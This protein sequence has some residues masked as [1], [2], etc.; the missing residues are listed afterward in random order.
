L[1][2]I[3]FRAHGRWPNLR[4]PKT[5][6]EKIQYRKLHQH[7]ERFVRLADK[8]LVKEY[9]TKRLGSDWVIPTLWSGSALP[10]RDERLWPI[11]FVLKATHGSSTNLF[12]RS[13][14]EKN[15]SAT[16]R[17]AESWLTMTYGTWAREW[18]YTKI[19][20]RL[21]VEPFI[22]FDTTLPLDYK[23]FVFHGRVAYIQVD[24]D[25]EH[26]H[27][28]AV[29]TRD[30]QPVDV[31]FGVDRPVSQPARPQ[32][33]EAMLRAAETLG[34]EFDFVRVDFYEVNGRPLFGEMTFYPD[35][36]L[37]TFTPPS[38]DTELG[39]LWHIA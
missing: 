22:N 11:P 14:A 34:A 37:G 18:L 32:T 31:R 5:F 38:F 10:P 20:P 4:T 39:A 2:I 8:A 9:V 28:R 35:S 12:V 1:A 17:L 25:R 27:R 33:L 24:T 26:D 23:F 3:Y 21:L 36:G 29:Y 7:D 19:E 15:W 30:W 13:E 16:E 6:N